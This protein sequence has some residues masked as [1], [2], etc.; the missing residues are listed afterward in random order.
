MF[1]SSQIIVSSSQTIPL[2]AQSPNPLTKSKF[3]S[4]FRHGSLI[5]SLIIYSVFSYLSLIIDPSIAFA[6]CVQYVVLSPCTTLQKSSNF[7]SSLPDKTLF[8]WWPFNSCDYPIVP[9]MA[10]WTFHLYPE[11]HCYNITYFPTTEEN[12]KPFLQSSVRIAL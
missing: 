11:L 2:L 7:F 1:L 10:P 8:L 4:L 12:V 9:P 5:F 3:T 6:F